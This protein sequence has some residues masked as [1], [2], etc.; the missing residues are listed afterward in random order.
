MKI[1]IIT[2]VYNRVDEILK[3]IESVLSQS[4]LNYEHIIIDGLSNDGSLEVIK[5]VHNEKIKLISEKDNGI[6]DALNKGISIS[7]GDVIGVL[8]SDDYYANSEIFMNVADL[9]KN[10]DLDMVFGDVEFFH[11]NNEK[12]IRRYDSG[13]FKPNRIKYGVMPAHPSMFLR[14]CFYE[15]NLYKTNYKIAADFEMIARIFSLFNISYHYI[16][17]TMVRMQTGGVS[18]SGIKANLLLNKEI[19]RACQE[20]GYKTNWF[21]IL[22]KYPHKFTEYFIK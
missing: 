18:T 17:S 15:N 12:T 9:F 4:Y 22:L 19:I 5:S 13:F 21:N 2:V 11:S 7:S 3:C 1:S 6:F 8:N 16:P 14:S 10:P 20:N